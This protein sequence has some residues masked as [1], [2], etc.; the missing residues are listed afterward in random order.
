MW[1]HK[2][3]RRK[4]DAL[5]SQFIRERSHWLCEYCSKDF[6][7]RPGALHCSHYYGRGRESVRFDPDNCMALCAY[8]HHYLGHSDHHDM[9]KII[10]E[11]KL[12]KRGFDLLTLRANTYRKRDDIMDLLYIQQ[13]LKEVS[14][15]ESLTLFQP[16]SLFD[17]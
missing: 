4:T 14:K 17:Y 12:G 1:Q 9:Y 5:F 6:K 13:L 7:G 11:K 3:K 8:H 2:V 16:I 10:M 15:E